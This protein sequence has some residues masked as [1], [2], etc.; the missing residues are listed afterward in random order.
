LVPQRC[1]TSHRHTI[2]IYT[3]RSRRTSKENG[4]KR[5]KKKEKKETEIKWYNRDTRGLSFFF[6]EHPTEKWR[7]KKY[8]KPKLW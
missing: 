2:E 4:K 8:L 1:S 3:A 6:L 7:K 5:K